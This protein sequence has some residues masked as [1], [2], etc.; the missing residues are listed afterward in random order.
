[1]RVLVTGGAGYIGSHAVRALSRS[2][3][4][5]V[6]YD[7][8]STGHPRLAEGFELVIGDIRDEKKLS[9]ALPGVNAV[10]HF[11][12]SAYVGES[13]EHPRKYFDNNVCAALNLLNCVA[14]AGIRYFVFSSTCAI[15]GEPASLPI[16]EEMPKQPVSPY[17]I[18]K[19]FFESALRSYDVAYGIKSA[20]LRYFNAA[21]ADPEGRTGEVHD[22]ETHLIPLVLAA[23]ADSKQAI[24]IFGDD[25]PTADGTCVR[26]YIHVSDLADAH[27]LALEHMAR[28]EE[29]VEL[30]LGT[31]EGYSVREIISMV[32]VVT[33]KKIPQRTLARRAGDPPTLVAD[34]RKAERV[35]G[36]KT[37][38]GLKE[39]IQHAWNWFG[40]EK[41][42]NLIKELV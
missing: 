7:N 26:D 41:R 16:V 4:E 18:S 36:W 24:N 13:V 25:Y 31:G 14:D 28:T 21:G 12:A 23:A 15:Y 39:I 32:E 27:V 42:H 2:G 5:V 40:S 34:P 17:G 20:R 33:G 8:L 10:L 35:L 29:S 37:K 1:M 6:V 11:A 3:H 30:N 9:S 38:Y 22:P 19:Q